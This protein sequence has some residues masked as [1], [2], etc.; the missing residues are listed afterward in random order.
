M[1][2]FYIIYRI[3]YFLIICSFLFILI[4][5]MIYITNLASVICIVLSFLSVFF[6]IY[7]WCFRLFQLSFYSTY[8]KIRS[9]CIIYKGKA[10]TFLTC[11]VVH[12][13]SSSWSIELHLNKVP[14]LH[15]CGSSGKTTTE[16]LTMFLQ[17]HRT[18]RTSLQI[19]HATG[20]TKTKTIIIFSLL[21]RVKKPS[22]PRSHQHSGPVFIWKLRQ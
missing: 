8:H 4:I 11:C 15:L 21:K 14:R 12:C 3:G 18:T 7:L 1:V 5:Y 17:T 19:L 16:F 22:S 9:I 20:D 6:T 2:Q 13:V 10:H